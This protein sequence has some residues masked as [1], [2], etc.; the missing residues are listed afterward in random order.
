MRAPSHQQC[1]T[2]NSTNKWV[3]RKRVT[4]G[5]PPV[6]GNTFN[7]ITGDDTPQATNKWG[8]PKTGSNHC[9][10]TRGHM[11]AR[12]LRNDTSNRS[13][14]VMIPRRQPRL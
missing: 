12:L 6:V 14:S 4:K 8:P 11:V 7:A 1:N 3:T 10:R 13:A 2:T 5:C 9:A